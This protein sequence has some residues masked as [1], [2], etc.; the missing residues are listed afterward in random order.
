MFIEEMNAFNEWVLIYLFIPM[1]SVMQ[2]KLSHNNF[3]KKHLVN[4]Y[5][6]NG[7]QI[8]TNEVDYNSIGI[9]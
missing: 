6:K 7:K 8:I 5:N 3:I 2:E 9:R 1:P 4:L